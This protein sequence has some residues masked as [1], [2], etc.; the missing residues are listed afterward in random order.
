MQTWEVTIVRKW[1][2]LLLF[3]AAVLALCGAGTRDKPTVLVVDADV[4]TI[5]LYIHGEPYKTW[6]C[7]VGKSDT[8]SPLGVFTINHKAVDW[9]TGF[10]TRWLG[11]YCPYGRFGI[12]GTNKPA[13]IGSHASHGCVRM[14]NRDVEELYPLVPYGARV[15]I[16]RDAYGPMAAGLRTLAPGARGADVMQVQLRLKN[17]GYYY[18]NPDGVFG[19]NTKQALVR[20]RREAGLS[21][22]DRVDWNC[23]RALGISLFE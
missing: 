12:H 19:E 5:T 16:E 6:P 8:P 10:G 21:V 1:L 20:F 11:F 17:L 15:I 4:Q 7:A 14:L 18:G 9:G 22:S 23:Y 13:S 2:G 3:F